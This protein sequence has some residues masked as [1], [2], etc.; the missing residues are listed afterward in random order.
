ME[1]LKFL[2]YLLAV[3]FLS[4]ILIYGFVDLFGSGI[5]ETFSHFKNDMLTLSNKYPMAWGIG[6]AIFAISL[7][8]L[9]LRMFFA[10]HRP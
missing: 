8:I 1:V 9:G 6:Q 10:A 5:S 2:Y 3:V 4:A 7:L